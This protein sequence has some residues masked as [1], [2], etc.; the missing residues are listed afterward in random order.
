[1]GGKPR[2]SG[3]GGCCL[4]PW[5]L[6]EPMF[7]DVRRSIRRRGGGATRRNAAARRLSASRIATF[8]FLRVD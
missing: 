4:S 2:A 5:M 6:F 1:M 7:A 8:T 3:S